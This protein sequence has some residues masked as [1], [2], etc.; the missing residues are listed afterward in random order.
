MSRLPPHPQRRAALE[1]RHPVWVPRTTAQQLDAAAGEFADRPLILTDDHVYSYAEVQDWTVRLAA[2]LIALGVQPG[3][4]VAVDMANFP[5]VVALKYAV[6]R[7]GAV[8]VSVNF[9][10]RHEELRYVLHQSDA[11]VLII[12]DEFRGLDYLDALDQIAPGWERD[13]G[14]DWLPRLR[15]I[16]VRRTGAQPARGRPLEDLVKCG[17]SISDEAVFERTAAAD[18]FATSDLLYTSGTTG[19]A[20]GVMLQHDAVLRTAYA[21]AYTRAFQDGRRVLFALP[22]Y[23]VFGYVEATVAVLFVGGAICPH[24]IFDAGAL[25]RDIGRHQIHE[26]I[27]VPAMTTVV[28]ATAQSA[29]YDLSSLTTMFSSGAAHRPQIWAQ[30]LDVLGVDELFTAYGQTETTASTL[31]TAP[32]DPIELLMTTNG[33]PKPAGV[34]GDPALGGLLAVYRAVHP[35]TGLDVPPGEVGELV[36][37]GPMVTKGYYQKPDETAAVLD[38]E[39]W[40]HTGDLGQFDEHGYLTLTG[41]TKE[42]YRCGGEL[43]VPRE[44]ELVLERYPGVRSAHVVG[45][46]HPRMGEVGCAWIV[47]AGPDKP[48]PAALIAYCGTRLARF[49]VPAVVLFTETEDLPVT[50]TGRVQKFRLTERALATL[51]PRAVTPA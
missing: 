26:L 7:V 12:M 40:L 29:D 21:S 31:C 35:R 51:G 24:P 30:I 10:L 42:S 45:I 14:G 11:T 17:E 9:L 39:G 18:P 20:K 4:H 47:P 49:K 19:M 3:D 2:G 44:V 28:L 41:R 27:C 50:V 5:D 13:A 43:V 6:A 36:V 22:I 34:A 32:G 16:F 15:H 23:H 37:R 48:D 46:P 8:S 25:L 33:G 1:A 38:S